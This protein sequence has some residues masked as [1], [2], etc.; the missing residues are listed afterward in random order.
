MCYIYIQ[1]SASLEDHTGRSRFKVKETPP[2]PLSQQTRTRSRKRVVSEVKSDID[3]PTTRSRPVKKR[4]PF[5]VERTAK[6]K[7]KRRAARSKRKRKTADS[8]SESKEE[9]SSTKLLTPKQRMTIHHDRDMIR[10]LDGFEAQGRLPK[11]ELV[12]SA[13]YYKHL[14]SLWTDDIVTATGYVLCLLSVCI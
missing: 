9:E 5:A 8:G 2:P 4:K 7:R 3:E 10:Y 13:N 6:R 1:A 12:H 11:D 14:E